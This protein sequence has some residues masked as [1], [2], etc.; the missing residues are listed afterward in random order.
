M[1]PFFEQATRTEWS[2]QLANLGETAVYLLC[3][4]LSI[5][6]TVSLEIATLPTESYTDVLWLED[7]GCH[8]L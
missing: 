2:R 1:L 7:T 6:D 3:S 5:Y 4:N 8:H